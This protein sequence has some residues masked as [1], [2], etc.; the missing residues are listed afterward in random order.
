MEGTIGWVD[1]T[2]ERKKPGVGETDQLPEFHSVVLG[3]RFIKERKYT[4]TKMQSRSPNCILVDVYETED[5]APRRA[6][7]RAWQFS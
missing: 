3:F 5:E 2:Q 1:V 6:N 7:M 4:V